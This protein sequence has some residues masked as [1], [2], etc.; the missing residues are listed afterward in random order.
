MS[1][2]IMPLDKKCSHAEQTS[3]GSNDFWRRISCKTC[4]GTLAVVKAH[5]LTEKSWRSL[6][7]TPDAPHRLRALSK[8]EK[9]TQ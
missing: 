2:S 1:V 7:L 6:T 3:A 4:G 5:G 8:E 9:K